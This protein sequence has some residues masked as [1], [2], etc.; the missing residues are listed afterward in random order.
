MCYHTTVTSAG[1][2]FSLCSEPRNHRYPQAKS[3]SGRFPSASGSPCLWTQHHSEAIE[4]NFQTPPQAGCLDPSERNALAPPHLGSCPARSSAPPP[5]PASGPPL[6]TRMLPLKLLVRGDV[7]AVTFGDS[8]ACSRWGRNVAFETTRDRVPAVCGAW[9]P[10]GSRRRGFC[11]CSACQGEGSGGEALGT[12]GAPWRGREPPRGFATP[13]SRAAARNWGAEL[14]REGPRRQ[15]PNPLGSGLDPRR[16]SGSRAMLR[17][18]ALLRALRSCSSAP[19]ARR[20][21]SAK[22]SVRDALRAQNTNGE[23]VK[24]QVGV[25]EGNRLFLFS[26]LWHFHASAC[27]ALSYQTE[28]P[29]AK[30]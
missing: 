6:L 13:A 8:S 4:M 27:R 10:C 30:S 2:V 23:R 11:P 5:P 14:R 12:A 9:S 29:A 18:W 15:G 19:C 26:D 21:P 25:W 17:T 3:P 20:K 16:A 22:L 7:G 1:A 28:G 24:V